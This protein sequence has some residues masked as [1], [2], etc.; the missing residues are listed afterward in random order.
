MQDEFSRVHPLVNCIYFVLV[1]A[2]SALILDPIFVGISALSG[3]AYG[4]YLGREHFRRFALTFILPVFL[5]MVIINPLV[6]HQG[7]TILGYFSN[8]NPF[9]LEAVVYGI[10]SGARVVASIFWCYC[11]HKIMTTDKVMALLGNLMPSLSLILSMILRLIPHYE[12]EATG[13]RLV[14]GRL[15]ETTHMGALGKVRQ[16]IKEFSI[17]LTWGLEHG[18]TTAT[19]MRQ[20]GYG[21]R[22]ATSYNLYRFRRQDLFLLMGLLLSGGGLGM[23]LLYG[24]MYF[25]C[26]PS[27]MYIPFC[28]VKGILYTLYGCLTL[29]PLAMEIRRIKKKNRRENIAYIR[30]T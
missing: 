16:G 2:S 6:N 24:Y 3:C 15:A 13:I 22:K 23:G 25:T 20:R 4:I 21:C 1:I 9:T 18:V 8:G 14:Q 7:L 5:I 28:L 30:R 27:V 26:F 17:L 11:F 10:V 19:S 12:R 29:M